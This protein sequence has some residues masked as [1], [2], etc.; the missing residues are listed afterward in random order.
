MFRVSAFLI[1]V[2]L[3][4]PVTANAA[5]APASYG[6]PG[7]GETPSITP[8]LKLG[9]RTAAA[10]RHNGDVSNKGDVTYE[11]PIELPP[12]RLKPQ[13]ALSY[14]SS[15]GPDREL[16]YGWLLTGILEARHSTVRAYEETDL[17]VA[18]LFAGILVQDAA[19]TT[20]ESYVLKSAE[21]LYVTAT[22]V[23][24]GD[25]ED[26]SFTIY[27]GGL[28]YT[29]DYFP[30][31]AVYRVE[32]ITDTFGNTISFS[33]DEG[34]ISQIEYGGNDATGDAANVR[35]T[36]SYTDNDYPR[37]SFYDSAGQQVG[38]DKHLTS[39]AIYTKNKGRWTLQNAV[40]LEYTLRHT[41]NLLTKVSLRGST[42]RPAITL[43]TFGYSSFDGTAATTRASTDLPLALQEVEFSG[44]SSDGFHGASY[45][46]SLLTDVT[47]DGLADYLVVDSSKEFTAYTQDV[48]TTGRNFSFNATGWGLGL[49]DSEGMVM[50]E[51]EEGLRHSDRPKYS[52]MKANLVDLDGDGLLDYVTDKD[53]SG[54]FLVYY[55]EGNRFATNE[56]MEQAPWAY[57]QTGYVPDAEN[58]PNWNVGVTE[59]MVDINGDDWLDLVNGEEVYFHTG[60]RGGGWSETSVGFGRG[61][62]AVQMVDYSTAVRAITFSFDN[63][64]SACED[65]CEGLFWECAEEVCGGGSS[66]YCDGVCDEA[67]S[68]YDGETY[69]S[70]YEGCID[71]CES[72]YDET[73]CEAPCQDEYDECIEPCDEMRDE[74]EYVTFIRYNTE[75]AGFHDLNGDGLPDYVNAN[76]APWR[77]YL[78]RGDGTFEDARDWNAPLAIIRRIDEGYSTIIAEVHY[79]SA[80]DTTVNVGAPARLIADLIDVDGDGLLDWVGAEDLGSIWYRNTGTGFAGVA[81]ALPSWWADELSSTDTTTDLTYSIDEDYTYVNTTTSMTAVMMDMDHDGALD[82]VDATGI[83][84]GVYPPPYL[85]TS[86]TS[87]P[88]AETAVTYRSSS[89]VD[90]SDDTGSSW[91]I[92]SA[93]QH[94]V[95]RR[96]LADTITTADP[97]TGQTGKTTFDFNDGAFIDGVFQGFEEQTVLQYLNDVMTSQTDNEFEL[98]AAYAPLPTSSRLRTDIA[99]SFGAA[100]QRGRAPAFGDRYLITNAYT[101]AGNLRLLDTRGVTEYGETSTDTRTFELDYDWDDYGNLKVF[102]HD[103]GGVT[104]DAYWVSFHYDADSTGRFYRMTMRGVYGRDP[105]NGDVVRPFTMDRYYYDGATTGGGTITDGLLT[106]IQTS[107]GWYDDTGNLD[108]EY[109]WT[110]YEYGGR[111]EMTLAQDDT[112]G[113]YVAMTY[114]FSDAMVVTQTNNLSQTM[115]YGLNAKGQTTSVTDPNGVVTSLTLDDFGRVTQTS[116]TDSAASTAT[117]ESSSFSDSTVPRYVTTSQYNDSGSVEVT[118]YSVMNGF[119]DVTQLWQPSSTGSSYLVSDFLRDAAGNLIKTEHPQTSR[120][121][122]ATAGVAITETLQRAYYDGLG[123]LREMKPDETKGLGSQEIYFNSPWQEI[124]IDSQNYET[125]LMYDAHHRIIRVKQ[126]KSNERVWLSPEYYR[127]DPLH[128]LVKFVDARGNIYTYSYDGLG[129]L[130]QVKYGPDESSLTTWYTYSYDGQL[131]KRSEDNTGGYSEWEY[132]DLGRP[133]SQTVSDGLPTSSGIL[134]YATDGAGPTYEWTYDTKW[135]GAVSIMEDPSG[136]T[137]FEYDAAG[138][139]AST[140]RRYI[141][142]GVSATF[143]TDFDV[144]KRLTAQT[145]PS[146]HELGLTYSNGWLTSQ[147]GKTGSTTDYTINYSYNRWGRLSSVSSSRG[148]SL[149]YTYTTPLYLDS[150]N[151]ATARFRPTNYTRAYAWYSNGLLQSRTE[152]GSSATALRYTYDDLMQLTNVMQGTATVES[153]DYDSAGVLNTMQDDS[154]DDWTYDTAGGVMGQIMGR[155]S[156]SGYSDTYGYDSAGRL[157]THDAVSSSGTSSRQYYYDGLG[158]LRAVYQDGGYL[159][160]FDYDALGNLVRRADADPFTDSPNY[161][162]IYGDWEYDGT[163]VT[164][165]YTSFVS[166]QNGTRVWKMKEYDGHVAITLNDSGTVAG[167]RRLGAYGRELAATGTAWTFESF[168]GNK[169]DTRTGDLYHVGSRHMMIKDGQW[170]GPDPQLYGGIN[171]VYLVDPLSLSPYRYGRNSPYSFRDSTGQ[172]VESAIDIASLGVGAYSISQWDETT[173]T[174]AKILDVA[175]VAADAVA[176]ILPGIPGGVSALIRAGRMAGSSKVIKTG[177]RALGKLNHFRGSHFEKFVLGMDGMAKYTGAKLSGMVNGKS[178]NFV[179]DGLDLAQGILSEVKNCKYV[180]K[181]AKQTNQILAEIDYAVRQGLTFRLSVKEGTVINPIIQSAIQAASGEIHRVHGGWWR[182]AIDNVTNTLRGANA[183]DAME[184]EDEETPPPEEL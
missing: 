171:P 170:L 78:G 163:T 5:V 100:I 158:R 124:R 61:F 103:G 89:S 37:T 157:T 178:V 104:S 122:S 92:V 79:D 53:G 32:T 148:P 172:W 169:K 91:R 59:G 67:C 13:L 149:S 12:A 154:G 108:G 51:V 120:T 182:G 181:N 183:A 58:F 115:T 76:S 29:M 30:E 116:V 39:I 44:E 93:P 28:E 139:V 119:G 143:T 118:S 128:R 22:F 26:N 144:Q 145:F 43:A 133:T 3:T 142:G 132:D 8:L 90:L 82:A 161:T 50:V 66:D 106:G 96:H 176:L 23:D 18:G 152:D 24:E 31:G 63:V 77:V 126:G 38:F 95:L 60:T 130:R 17:I 75:T 74:T 112:T 11:V 177:F 15:H 80:E 107:S 109:H 97:I 88:G 6:T 2:F 165:N 85:L 33:Y 35:L 173:T 64:R 42:A 174:G 7:D 125:L 150:V 146:G 41:I 19:D 71:S 168:H 87:G 159:E 151:L 21:P 127:Y 49:V 40:V 10:A 16:G 36:F 102:R 73:E 129:R 179:P 25:R 34:R 86:V 62:E 117:V 99:L 69:D 72:S 101:T 136:T 83:V 114:G 1:L 4:A 147:T 121:F 113:Q 48:S 175:G 55:G 94:M 141:N 52:Y 162:D 131:L 84:Y 70:C 140:E 184:D 56:T 180:G 14:A 155:S 123:M 137:E 9:S 156:S 20:G 68:D 46:R 65:A 98:S 45:V 47:G 111:G 110:T 135:V 153:Y 57:L 27:S 167:T 81:E 166:A 160:V 54:E 134:T 138:N 164:E 105:L